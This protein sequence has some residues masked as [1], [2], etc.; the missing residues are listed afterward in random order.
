M[1]RH[2]ETNETPNGTQLTPISEYAPTA[3]ALADLQH[4]FKDRVFES[5]DTDAQRKAAKKDVAEVRTYRTALEEE[6]KRIKAPALERCRLIDAEAQRLTVALRALEDPMKA[7]IDAKEAELEA[8]RAR[9]AQAE[10]QRVQGHLA[11]IQ[12]LRAFPMTLQGRPAEVIEARIEAFKAAHGDGVQGDAFEEF[13][14]QARD[15][16]GASLLSAYDLH[17][18]QKDLEAEQARA[19]QE[20][21]ELALQR[22]ENERLQRELEAHRRAEEVRV[23][24]EREA[25]EARARAEQEAAF[26]KAVQLDEQIA[27]VCSYG[28]GLLQRSSGELKRQLEAFHEHLD[29]LRG[30]DFGAKAMEA[31]EVKRLV[32]AGLM[33]AIEQA[34]ARE[35]TALAEQAQWEQQQRELDAQ[36]EVQRLAQAQLEREQQAH[37]A[38]VEADRLQALTLREAALAAVRW[39]HHHGYETQKV[40][41]DLEHALG[42][43]PTQRVAAKP[44]RKPRAST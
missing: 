41:T 25:A 20:R 4:R 13:A 44:V 19:A 22:E 39:F 24:Q 6:R 37:A 31:M 1:N 11:A 34:L 15:A 12:A 43:E 14:E 3:V 27:A 33:E 30:Y 26:R 18:R 23:Q 36:A 29:S 2:D 32:E 9:K 21:A 35:E 7:Q 10:A 17:A 40:C 5:L 8:E 16:F 38:Q 42:A 28:T